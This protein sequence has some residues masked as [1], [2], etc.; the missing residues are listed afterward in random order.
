MN[1]YRYTKLNNTWSCQGSKAC[2]E[3][4]HNDQDKQL[5]EQYFVSYAVRG[6]MVVPSEGIRQGMP[7][8]GPISGPVSDPSPLNNQCWYDVYDGY[9]G[10]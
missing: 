5:K 9:A 2:E 1:C 10:V 4:M 8:T 6:P 7:C 3:S